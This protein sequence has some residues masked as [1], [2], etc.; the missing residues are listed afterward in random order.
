[1]TTYASQ[2]DPRI[3]GLNAEIE[4]LRTL[5]RATVYW[6]GTRGL[7]PVLREQVEAETRDANE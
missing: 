6:R 5:L 4:R 1:M 2:C 3:D 7:P